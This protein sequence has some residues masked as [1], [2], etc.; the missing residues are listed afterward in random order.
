[1]DIVPQPE[2]NV[3][4]VLAEPQAKPA[5][6]TLI[7]QYEASARYIRSKGDIVEVRHDG[8]V[9]PP[10]NP[11]PDAAYRWLESNG[12]KP[13]NFQRLDRPGTTFQARKRLRSRRSR[14]GAS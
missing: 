11:D 6:I 13:V 7:V 3:K 2:R 1:M 12:Y 4:N 8:I 5:E 9:R 10:N 14:S